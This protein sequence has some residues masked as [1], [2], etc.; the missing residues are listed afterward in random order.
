MQIQIQIQMQIQMQIQIQIQIQM[1]MQMQIHD[2]GKK[3]G[4]QSFH[5]RHKYP[6]GLFCD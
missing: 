1:Q 4:S 6:D 2:N 3:C 5:L